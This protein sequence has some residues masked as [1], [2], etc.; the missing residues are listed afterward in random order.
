VFNFKN[1]L[2]LLAYRYV[3]RVWIL[4][5]HWKC[6]FHFILF[7]MKQRRGAIFWTNPH[8]R[9]SCPFRTRVGVV[10]SAP[11][12]ELSAPHPRWSCPFR[13]RIGV[14]WSAPALELSVP[15]PRWSCPFRTR[16]G[17]VRFL[18]FLIIFWL[19]PSE[20]ASTV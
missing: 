20:F 13:T 7:E 8:P 5:E 10:R 3:T 11:A 1:W 12:L 4:L 9:W 18:S 2:N 6:L 16:V 15:H 17:V 14:V 19:L